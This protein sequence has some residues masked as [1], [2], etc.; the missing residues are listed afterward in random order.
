M[1]EKALSAIAWSA[2]EIIFRQGVQF[3]VSIVLARL[4]TPEEFG[5][6]ALLYLFVGI[7]GALA[8]GGLTTALIQ[9]QDT[10]AV[11]E[12]TVF[13]QNMGVGLLMALLFWLAGPAIAA[14]YG[15]PVLEPLAAVMA[16]TVV[17]TAAGAVQRALLTKALNFRPLMLAGVISV[18]VSGAV[19]IWL[20]LSGYGV[21]ALAAQALTG[22]AVTTLVV[23]FASG[24]RPGFVFSF[25][26]ARL[27]LGFGGYMLASAL[28][29]AAYSRLYTVLIGKLHGVRELG[30]YSRADQT[31]M[32][33][34]AILNGIVARVAL[35]LFS[36][37]ADNPARLGVNLRLTLQ[38]AMLV[39][40]PAMLGL[41]AVAEPLVLVL[42]GEQ[43][44]PAVI[45]LQILCLAG[46]MMP[47]HVLNL[48]ALLGLGHSK[49]FFHMVVMKRAIGITAVVTAASFGALGVAWSVVVADVFCY[50]I[51]AYH[52]GKLLGY[53]AAAQLR[54]T[55]PSM[56]AAGA[57][58]AG[59]VGLSA[60]LGGTLG[61]ADLL[62]V[63]VAAGVTLYAMIVF[64]FRLTA[65]TILLS[66]VQ[67]RG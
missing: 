55:I 3:G 37:M 44:R 67:K 51:N 25:A 26:S 21:W 34:S 22:A 16:L 40:A 7:A 1:R 56:A 15:V 11:D 19:A 27:L 62:L 23:W 47:L 14:L 53:G 5:T 46:L 57:M 2:A 28:L 42:F 10:T 33:P 63:S 43:W 30:Y 31:A 38:G 54:D 13:W 9:R 45:F 36:R 59:I 50:F 41:A 39:N 18:L 20:A 66:L 32:F 35:P 65:L 17:A 52:S 64:A 8:E 61:P 60:W 48:Q 4:L 49:Q 58:A 29:D 12:S 6:V 24:W